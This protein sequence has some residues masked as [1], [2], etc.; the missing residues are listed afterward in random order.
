MPGCCSRKERLPTQ[1]REGGGQPDVVPQ[2][3]QD[4][5]L[6][7]NRCGLGLGPGH[8]LLQDV[9]P[10]PLWHLAPHYLGHAPLAKSPKRCAALSK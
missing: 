1:G 8:C 10:C 5:W 6:L 2:P 3:H 4:R 9:F 7:G